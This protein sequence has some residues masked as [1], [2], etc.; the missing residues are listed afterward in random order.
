LLAAG[1]VPATDDKQLLLDHVFAR[2]SGS[3]RKA[4]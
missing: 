2:A 3:D 1:P 4:A